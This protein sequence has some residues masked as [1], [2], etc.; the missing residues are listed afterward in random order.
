MTNP[1]TFR[2][3]IGHVLRRMPFTASVRASMDVAPD[4]RIECRASAPFRWSWRAVTPA[5]ETTGKARSMSRALAAAEAA[6]ANPPAA[7]APPAPTAANPRLRRL[8]AVPRAAGRLLRL[9][10]VTFLVS[11]R[12]AIRIVC[13]AGLPGTGYRWS[14]RDLAAGS[15][16]K[17]ASYDAAVQAARA[18]ADALAEP[19]RQADQL[20]SIAERM[21]Q[22]G[23]DEDALR[24][25]AIAESLR[26]RGVYGRG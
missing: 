10:D 22:R 6:V 18:A 21:R 25:Y 11:Q 15:R 14:V 19:A 13:R 1:R 12:G 4:G 5:G 17:A 3:R 9:P 16:G 8:R 20:E 24:L 2:A 26:E 23:D 7:L